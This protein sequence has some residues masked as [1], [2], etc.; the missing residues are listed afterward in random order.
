MRRILILVLF[1]AAALGLAAH[2]TRPGEAELSALI[3]GMVRE[4]VASSDIDASG[5]PVATMA[6]AACKL[7]PSDCAG[8]VR[9]A[10]DVRLVR[11]PLATRAVIAGLGRKTRC[12]GVFGRY[13]CRRP[14]RT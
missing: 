7:R 13:F 4:R 8:L 12:L 11:G 9:K 5:D 14:E 10:L 2:L 3:E 6:L 1:A